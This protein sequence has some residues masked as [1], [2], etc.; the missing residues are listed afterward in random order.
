VRDA[1]MITTHREQ[2]DVTVHLFIGIERS[3]GKI[4]F[5]SLTFSINHKAS[6]RVLSSLFSFRSV[7]FFTIVIVLSRSSFSCSFGACFS[8]LQTAPSYYA[9][10]HL[11]AEASCNS[12]CYTGKHVS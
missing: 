10:L 6:C 3:P 9:H 2:Y 4:T 5:I 12:L 8:F 1:G 11:K 7:P